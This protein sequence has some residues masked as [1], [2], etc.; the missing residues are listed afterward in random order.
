MSYTRQHQRFRNTNYMGSYQNPTQ[1]KTCA[2]KQAN[3]K[4]SVWLGWA[5]DSK[6][7]NE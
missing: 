4:N 2:W 3:E 1:T 7:A 5:D 6:G